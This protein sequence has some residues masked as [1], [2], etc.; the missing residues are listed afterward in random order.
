M[1]LAFL[2]DA[3]GNALALDACLRRAAELEVDAVYFLGDAVGYLPDAAGVVDRLVA[4]GVPCQQG[5][6]EAML[7][8]GAPQP[9]E[10]E[11]AYR[12]E[13]ARTQL[14][15]DRLRVLAS[16]PVRR[17]LTC[18]GARLLLVHGSPLAPLDEYVY[19]DTD[20]AHLAGQPFDAVVMGHTHR[21]FIRPIGPT[22]F[23]NAGSV[24]LPRDHGNLAAFAVYDGAARRFEIVRVPLDVGAILATYGDRVA[25]VVRACLERP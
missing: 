15:A 17:E 19:P 9:P 3:H 6:H 2:S 8:S 24:G 10:R 20:L 16:W 11:A 18:D 22:T 7:L 1:R 14:G 12:L 23:V 4:A 5:N 13:A 25:D 21:P